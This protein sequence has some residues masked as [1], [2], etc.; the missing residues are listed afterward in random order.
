M[1]A[2]PRPCVK[3]C[4]F[5]N[6]WQIEK[7]ACMFSSPHAVFDIKT[8]SAYRRKILKQAKILSP[9]VSSLFPLPLSKIRP[10]RNSNFAIRANYLGEI[11]SGPIRPQR[12]HRNK[13]GSMT[14]N[15]FETKLLRISYD[16]PPPNRLLLC[17][18]EYLFSHDSS[19]FTQQTCSS[20]F[21]SIFC[22]HL[23]IK[24]FD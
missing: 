8:L 4:G 21:V 24:M 7:E 12:Q 14:S 20:R 18:Q 22:G 23:S 13:A 19:S 15:L 1:A 17:L 10:S 3:K 11:V 16:E 5:H 6:G 2:A 9:Q